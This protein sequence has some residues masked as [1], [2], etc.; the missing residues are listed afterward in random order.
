M[1]ATPDNPAYTG[2]WY[3]THSEVLTPTDV[4]FDILG[5]T[6]GIGVEGDV[7]G[8]YAKWTYTMSF[9][10]SD[11]STFVYYFNGYIN[12]QVQFEL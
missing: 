6:V 5:H 7:L 8:L 12:S 2:K 1:G 11:P 9:D 4:G 10:F 3:I